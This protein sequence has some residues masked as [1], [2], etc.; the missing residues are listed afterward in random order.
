MQNASGIAHVLAC[1]GVE[2]EL[3]QFVSRR[4]FPYG[5][6]GKLFKEEMEA[7]AILGLY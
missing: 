5:E 4:R 2:E 1:H 7:A 3:C 6:E